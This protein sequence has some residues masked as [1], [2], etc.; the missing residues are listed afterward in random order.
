[1]TKRDL[2]KIEENSLDSIAQVLE[3]EFDK[4][5]YEDFDRLR[6]G[7]YYS[8]LGIADKVSALKFRIWKSLVCANP[9]EAI[10]IAK[11][12]NKDRSVST[13][14]LKVIYC[15]YDRQGNYI[16]GLEPLFN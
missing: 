10:K 6:G 11:D 16:G 1:M 8:I 4:R 15:A 3:C 5:S 7:G 13:Y 12:K 2:K 14:S 9:D